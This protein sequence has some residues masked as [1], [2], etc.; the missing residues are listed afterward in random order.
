MNLAKNI[1]LL[2]IT[3]E[4]MGNL[5]LVLAWDDKNLVLID[6]GLPG[7]TDDIV[8]AI[9]DAGFRAEDL[10]HIILTHQ[11][12]DH[13]GCVRDLQKH[14]PSLQ[15]VA[16]TEEAPY[17]DGRKLPIKLEARLAQLDTLPDD[18]RNNML[19]WKRTYEDTPV[20]VAMEV[21]DGQMIPICGGIEIIHTPGHTPG[22]IVVYFKENKLLVCGDAAN[23]ADGEMVMFNKIHIQD[24]AQAEQSL[25][26]IKRYDV[27]GVVAY[28]T[29]YLSL[30]P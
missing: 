13:V 16:H 15:V 21:Q 4:G 29:G 17:I 27:N 12:W 30:K 18:F 6:A 10:T 23:V 14:A 9:A 2:P 24:M 1:T 19:E 8:Q 28:H 25:E 5:N 26:K 7:Q 3:R 20:H 11:D 22:H